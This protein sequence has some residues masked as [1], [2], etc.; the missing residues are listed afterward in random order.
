[1]SEHGVSFSLFTKMWKGKS[2][3]ELGAFVNGLGF[4][5]IELPVRDG[6]PVESAS[7]Q[8]DLP[9]AVK[10]LAAADISIT[11]IAGQTDEATISAC[12]D[13]G[14]PVIRT[15]PDI[16]EEGYL[17]SIERHWRKFDS[18]I[19]LLEKH[20]VAIGIQNHCDQW[21]CNAMGL[22]H[23]IDRYDA[24][25][26]CAIPCTG[27][28]ALEGEPPEMAIDIIWSHLAQF[29]LK[30]AYWKRVNGPEAADVEWRPHW[31][32]GRQGRASWPRFAAELGS[33]GFAG[34]VCLDAEYSEEAAT[35]RLV[36]E[37]LAFASLCFSQQPP[38]A[39]RSSP[40]GPRGRVSHQH[41]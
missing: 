11:S 37:D 29:K 27:H 21:I 20:G 3:A 28:T 13:A 5:G 15:C 23:F 19:P 34:V 41:L 16:G 35:E 30:N 10:E 25:Q 40:S 17:A 14:V 31:T 1:M 39:C 33:R 36:I 22:K 12:G 8:A 4:D 38:V 7:V 2:I 6:Y 32:T 9:K 26:V 24:V 18:L